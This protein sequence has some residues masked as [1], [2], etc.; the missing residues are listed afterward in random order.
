MAS[1]N[2]SGSVFSPERIIWIQRVGAEKFH[3]LAPLPWKI[4][5]Q[6]SR[7]IIREDLAPVLEGMVVMITMIGTALV[8]HR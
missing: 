2:F 4:I 6:R 7:W 1:L 3:L 8:A 5:R